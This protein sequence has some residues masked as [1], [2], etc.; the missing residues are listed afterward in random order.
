[1]KEREE[2][3]LGAD[4]RRVALESEIFEGIRSQL[5]TYAERIQRTA[6]H[7]A[8]VDVLQSLA[9]VA[10]RRQYVRPEMHDG[11]EI[12]LENARHPVIESLVESGKFVPNDVHL[13][14]HSKQ[15]LMITGPNMAGKS[16]VMRQTALIVVMAQMG[17]FVPASN[18]RIGMVDQVF[19]RVGASDNLA[20]GQS[21]FM[22]EMVEAA[23]ILHNATARSLVIIDE[24]GRGTSTYD[25]VSIAWAVAEYLHDVIGARTL[26][27]THY[28]ELVELSAAKPRIVNMTIAVKEWQDEIVFLHRLIPGGTNRSY[29]IQVA[30]LAGL[31]ETVL[32]RSRAILSKLEMNGLDKESWPS[33]AEEEEKPAEGGWQLNLFATDPRWVKL[34]QRLATV[35]PDALSPREAHNLLYELKAYMRDEDT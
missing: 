6:A 30:R 19:T 35:E 8:E 4:E 25:G 34:R 22:V 17:G 21:T 14:D 5:A 29:G 3:V 31:P 11:S 15:L 28:H 20:G 26:F 33:L 12:R 10:A 7:V 16:T 13:D 24:I 23:R 2:K 18:A 32:N 1:M 27:A 9:E